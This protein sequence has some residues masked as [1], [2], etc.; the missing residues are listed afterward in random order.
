M[1]MQ[2]IIIF[3]IAICFNVYAFANTS[4]LSILR[5]TITDAE[6]GEPLKF[7]TIRA[8]GQEKKLQSPPNKECTSCE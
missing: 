7:V 6:T 5:G 4:D 2:R 1:N 3:M 8:I